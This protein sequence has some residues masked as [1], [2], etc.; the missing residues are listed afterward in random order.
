MTAY[1]TDIY[2]EQGATWSRGFF[3]VSAAVD[4]NGN[5]I[6]V[7]GKPIAGLPHWSNVIPTEAAMQVRSSL[8]KPPMVDASITNGQII[9][10]PNGRID[11]LIPPSGTDGTG[12][13][14]LIKP[15][16]VY[17]LEIQLGPGN[18]ARVMQGNA[19]ISLNVTRPV[20]LV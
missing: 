20:V 10:G 17:D 18:R 8:R 19:I 3:W 4:Q 1:I 2:M 16:G 6:L 5:E 9:L 14:G 15:E 11:I 13:D 7:N 12:S